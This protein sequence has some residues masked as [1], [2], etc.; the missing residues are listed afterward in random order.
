MRYTLVLV[1]LLFSQLSF[2]GK[3][4]KLITLDDLYRS[5]TFSMKSVPGFNAMKDGM[6]YSK[7]E[8]KDKN[9]VINI[10]SLADDGWVGTVFNSSLVKVDGKVIRVS[11]YEFS[12]DE[13]KLLLKTS[14]DPVY[15]HSVFYKTYV[16]DI[17]HK[18]I[19]LLTDE[20]SV[21]CYF[22]SRWF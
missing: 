18:R 11:G 10:Y 3:G 15:R 14:P 21:T 5:N 16:Y 22:L 7:L 20:K 13:T 2:A 17:V 12:D 4:D 6:R 19:N 8:T 9:Q 1:V